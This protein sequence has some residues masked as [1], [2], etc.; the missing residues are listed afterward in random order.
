VTYIFC[1]YSPAVSQFHSN[2]IRN[3]K[4]VTILR[5][6]VPSF[7]LLNL[8]AQHQALNTVYM[9]HTENKTVIHVIICK[10]VAGVLF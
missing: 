8:K 4:Y 3:T 5:A 7:Y 10:P 2:P 6:Y 1:R 9:F